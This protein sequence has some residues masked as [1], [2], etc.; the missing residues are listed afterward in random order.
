MKRFNNPGS[1]GIWN[2]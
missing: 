1:I 2:V